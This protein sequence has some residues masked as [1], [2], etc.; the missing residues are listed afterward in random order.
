ME[1]LQYFT[2]AS[3]CAVDGGCVDL[4]MDLEDGIILG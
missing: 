3:T 4:A 1:V 2:L